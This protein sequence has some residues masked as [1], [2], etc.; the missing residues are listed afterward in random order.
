MIVVPSRMGRINKRTLLARLQQMG[1]ASRADLAK[2]LGLSQPTSGKIVDQLL[3]L[4]AIEEVEVPLRQST[5]ASTPNPASRQVPR[6]GRPGRMLRLHRT[7][8]R[9][10]GIQLGVTETR[11]KLLPLGANG[12]DQWTVSVPTPDSAA[13]W[14]EE[15]RKAAPQFRSRSLWGVLISAPGIVDEKEAKV[16]FSPN[17]HWTEQTSL[18]ALV[19]EIWRV[20]VILAQEERVLALGHQALVPGS[21]DFLLVDVGEGVGGAVVV[22][23]K[24][25]LNPLP[26]SGELGHTPVV[27]NQ[28]SCGCGSVGCLETLIST[29][30]LMRSF[31]EATGTTR[32][33]WQALAT[34]V[35]AAGVAPWL[36]GALDATAGV[37]SGALN[38]MGLRQVVI[39]GSLNDLPL[40]VAGH[41]AAA[42]Q[43]GALWARF[44]EIG[45]EFAP[46][47]RTAGLVAVG[48]DR[49]VVPVAETERDQE[50]LLHAS[51]QHDGGRAA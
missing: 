33:S 41:L 51:A 20:P 27:G 1:V 48:L 3:E 21:R 39:T 35:A 4:G 29:R 24:L 28:R 8:P 37:I 12:E 34:H 45:V 32:P 17:L 31:A 6:L 18:P 16:I 13:L 42:I 36:A 14:Q 7:A 15:L 30:G 10:L 22:A 38:V 40:A 44:G 23:G 2:S 26:L 5:S 19:S 43:R 11:L 46:R 50:T 25:F 47:R 9:F 49:L